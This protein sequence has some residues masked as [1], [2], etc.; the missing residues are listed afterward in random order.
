MSSWREEKQEQRRETRPPFVP[1]HTWRLLQETPLK[2]RE[3][4]LVAHQTSRSRAP[5]HQRKNPPRNPQFFELLPTIPETH[6]TAIR[7]SLT[8]V[9]VELLI[10]RA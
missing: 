9:E 6:P 7:A 10:N 4:F 1:Q 5:I 2:T 8:G 3:L